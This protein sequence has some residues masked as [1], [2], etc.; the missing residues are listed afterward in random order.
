MAFAKTIEP[1]RV[2]RALRIPSLVAAVVLL[3]PVGSA[4]ATPTVAT[5]QSLASSA[6]P[7]A[8]APVTAPPQVRFAA[9]AGRELANTGQSSPAP[10]AA[11]SGLLIAGLLLCAGARRRKR[12]ELMP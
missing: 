1:R 11:A 3:N 2:R 7:G 12:K 8:P 9:P 10:L 5:S 6:C 4:Y